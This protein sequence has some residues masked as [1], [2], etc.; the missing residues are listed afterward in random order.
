M[1][2]CSYVSVRAHVWVCVHV[3]MYIHV[4]VYMCVHTSLHPTH[5]SLGMRLCVSVCVCAPMCVHIYGCLC[6]YVCVC[7][8]GCMVVVMGGGGLLCL[9]PLLRPCDWHPQSLAQLL[10]L[11]FL[12]WTSSYCAWWLAAS[13]KSKCQHPVSFVFTHFTNIV[14]VWL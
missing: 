8:S 14:T 9:S 13:I 3:C 12:K 7:M 5:K 2:A 11:S 6:V 1:G 10:F 4:H